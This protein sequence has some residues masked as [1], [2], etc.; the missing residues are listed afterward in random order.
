[1]RPTEA[2]YSHGVKEG[3]AVLIA[4]VRVVEPAV[5]L[6]FRSWGGF[7][8]WCHP[9]LDKPNR[10]PALLR[11]WKHCPSHVKMNTIR[12]TM[13]EH[14]RQTGR[15][16]KATRTTRRHIRHR[17]RFLGHARSV[18]TTHASVTSQIPSVN[19]WTALGLTACCDWR[20]ELRAQSGWLGGRGTGWRGGLSCL[21]GRS[22]RFRRC[23][24]ACDCCRSDRDLSRQGWMVRW[25]CHRE[26]GTSRHLLNAHSSASGRT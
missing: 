8:G 24:G 4:A 2:Q 9:I 10:M 16:C 23:Q 12:R 15:I 6:G 11:M 17:N 3:A 25:C 14:V 20:R 19:F 1:M 26:R 7:N 18:W 5:R 21:T 13:H 22:C